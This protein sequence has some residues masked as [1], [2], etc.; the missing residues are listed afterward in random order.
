M[1]LGPDLSPCL[2]PTPLMSTPKEW[3]TLG[4]AWRGSRRLGMG[5]GTRYLGSMTRLLS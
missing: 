1:D 2:V 4:A 3:E 5:V